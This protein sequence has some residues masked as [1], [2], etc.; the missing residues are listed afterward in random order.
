[1]DPP[2]RFTAK[3]GKVCKLEKAF[4]WI[5]AVTKGMVWQI[6]LLDERVWF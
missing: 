6:E 4:V 3:G 5:E 1:M 2:L